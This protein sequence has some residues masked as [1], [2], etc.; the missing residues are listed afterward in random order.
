MLVACS[1]LLAAFSGCATSPLVRNIPSFYISG[2]TYYSLV[3]L[4]KN[5][6]ATFRYDS[7]SKELVLDKDKRVV[8]LGVNKK[9]IK[10]NSDE[11]QISSAPILS[12]GVFLVSFEI[13]EIITNFYRQPEG[14]VVQS[15]KNIIRNIVVDPGHG[16]KDP[17]AIGKGGLKEKGVNLTIARYLVSELKR[18]GYNVSLTR[19]SDDFIELEDRAEI[20]NAKEA[21]L[22]ISVHA[23]ANKSRRLKGFE[24]YYLIDNADDLNR[25]LKVAE[26]QGLMVGALDENDK[27]LK[28]I[29]GDMYY[30][31]NRADSIGIA[32]SIC[33]S[34]RSGMD[35]N[36]LGVK[37]AKFCVLKSSH[38]AAV[39]VE[40]GF[41][42]NP[43]EEKLLKT[44]NYCRQ[45]AQTIAQ[46]ID[47]YDK[48]QNLRS[49]TLK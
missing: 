43:S 35:L 41:L 37:G 23:N 7:F 17:G 33:S 21:D 27:T 31:Q 12:E 38:M 49:S 1:L 13:V 36:I 30:A 16:G 47:E 32:K 28:A 24:V 5:L 14:P 9:I 40:V 25:L 39:L 2:N 34:A 3:S 19:N 45:V 4:A 20:A 22:F 48:K 18:L 11:R 44:D 6:E 46:G 15:Q 42:S 26:R 10:L 8:S 29:L